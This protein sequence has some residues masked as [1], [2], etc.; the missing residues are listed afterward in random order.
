MTFE[1]S[2]NLSQIH[3]HAFGINAVEDEN[4]D[5]NLKVLSFRGCNLRTVDGSLQTIFNQLEEFHLEGNPLNCNCNMK[6]I[7]QL[8]IETNARCHK[9]EVFRDKLLST[10]VPEKKMKC[11]NLFMRKFINTMILMLL[12]VSISLAIWFFLSRLN[13]SRKNKFQKVG[14]DSPYKRVTIE[15]NRA[16]Y[17]LY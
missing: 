7:K 16:E 11:E 10:E 5:V 8:A 15:P 9:P 2:R 1:A 17:S 12:L 4:I 3:P 13:P 14:P 6:W